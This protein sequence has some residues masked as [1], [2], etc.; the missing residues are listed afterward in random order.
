MFA[1]SGIFGH[2]VLQPVIHLRLVMHFFYKELGS[3]L[4]GAYIFKVFGTQ[5]CL[6]V[7]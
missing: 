1:R 7:A 3:D 4:K 5:S 6:M 2:L